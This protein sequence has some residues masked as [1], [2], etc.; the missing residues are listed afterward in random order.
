MCTIKKH[1]IFKF[2][3]NI[4]NISQQNI[5]KNEEAKEESKLKANV[6]N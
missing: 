2:N 4:L 1:Y 6:A 5:D 3:H